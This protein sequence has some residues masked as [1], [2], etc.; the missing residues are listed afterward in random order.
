MIQG[1]S[2]NFNKKNLRKVRTGNCLTIYK[3]KVLERKSDKGQSLGTVPA[4]APGQEGWERTTDYIQIPT[5]SQKQFISVHS[6]GCGGGVNVLS[7]SA[8]VP[9]ECNERHGSFNRFLKSSEGVDSH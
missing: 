6:P 3:E 1:K 5:Q 7:G 8:T 2:G 9:V 4:K